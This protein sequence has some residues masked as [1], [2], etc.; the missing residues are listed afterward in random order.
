VAEVCWITAVAGLS[1]KSKVVLIAA[2]RNADCHA[3]RMPA[4]FSSRSS[5]PSLQLRHIHAAFLQA[6]FIQTRA[7]AVWW[8]L[9][10][11]QHARLCTT[12]SGCYRTASLL[13]WLVVSILQG[14]VEQRPLCC[15][16]SCTCSLALFQPAPAAVLEP[17]QQR[18]GN[19]AAAACR[20]A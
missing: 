16:S 5:T 6:F 19:E 4:G 7:V 1:V 8:C 14:G 9:H 15:C 11:A 3:R 12:I 10:H 20:C 17:E 2:C 18:P 13:L